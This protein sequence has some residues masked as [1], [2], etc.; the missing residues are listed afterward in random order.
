MDQ[1]ASAMENIKQASL[2]N[3]ASTK[4]AEGAARNLHDLGQ[5]LKRLVE[6]YKVQA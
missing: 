4:Q 2:Q 3:I 5:N 6:R 1:L